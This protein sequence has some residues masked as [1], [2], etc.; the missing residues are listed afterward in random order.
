MLHAYSTTRGGKASLAGTLPQEVAQEGPGM[1]DQW[2]PRKTTPEAH[3]ALNA[4][5]W[6]IAGSGSGVASA[7]GPEFP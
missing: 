2:V 7:A 4:G 5:P 1:I 6:I 3:P